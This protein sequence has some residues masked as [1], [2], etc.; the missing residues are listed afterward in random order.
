M[1]GCSSHNGAGKTTTINMLTGLFPPQLELQRS[2][3][4][5]YA[6]VSRPYTPKWLYVRNMTSCGHD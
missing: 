4:M 2:T 6:M 3:D 1:H 5:I